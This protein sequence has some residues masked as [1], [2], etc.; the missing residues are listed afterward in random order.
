MNLEEKIKSNIRE[1]EDFPK[2]GIMFKD[3]TSLMLDPVLSNEIIEGFVHHLKDIQIDAVCAIESRG[4]LYGMLLAHALQVPFITIR[5]KGKLPGD[6][7]EFTYELEYGSSTVEVHLSDV[8]PGWNVLIHDDL[9]ATGGTAAAAAELMKKLKA[10]VAGYAFIVALS[11][12]GGKERLNLYT[13]KIVSLAT[14]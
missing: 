12:L 2:K 3:I 7:A 11:F 14:Y 13:D 1:V 8:Q 4:F 6:T 10:N 9:L 5:K